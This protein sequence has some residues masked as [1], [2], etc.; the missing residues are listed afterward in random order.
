MM[1][2]LWYMDSGA[3][4]HMSRNKEFFSDLEEND[5]QMH[6]DMGYYGRYNASDTSTITFQR[7][8]VS[9]LKN[10]DVMHLLG[11]KENLSSITIL[12]DHGYDVIFSK[13]KDFL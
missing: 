7:E 3:S 9:P 13:G 12:E 1:G 10:K 2:I 5:L 6:I 8:F 4:F 11:L